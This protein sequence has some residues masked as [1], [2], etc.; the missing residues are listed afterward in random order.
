MIGELSALGAAMIWTLSA[1]LYRKALS[2][3]TPFQA[4]QVRFVSASIALVT[5]L[6]GVGKI[7]ILLSLTPTVVLFAISSSIIGLV[8][9]DTFYLYALKSAGI[10]RTVPLVST[11]PLFSIPIA[12][13]L[14]GE[15]I[16]P[17]IVLGASII[18]VGIWLL[19]R[20]R[21]SVSCTRKM[22]TLR[23]H[24]VLSL[25]AALAYSIGLTLLSYAVSSVGE[26]GLE[27]VLAIHTV[28]M[29][30]GCA[31][32]L[33]LSPIFSQN[34]GFLRVSWKNWV[35]LASGG[36]VSLGLGTFLLSFSLLHIQVARAI[37]IS[38]TTPFF[39][40]LAGATLFR[41]PV[42]ASTILGSVL[43]VLGIF[44]LF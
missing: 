11:Y 40:V 26:A 44:L 4:N 25:S 41:E 34:L 8:L 22:K 6:V 20:S 5:F 21:N 30:I 14:K 1:V 9:G 17:F 27:G 42:R 23:K 3:I 36:L 43:V 18:V 15:K 32:L 37:P 2:T 39:S 16:T 38:S 31:V 24:S 10:A 7:E 13:I 28:R 33:S 12:F 19:N 35:L 29:L